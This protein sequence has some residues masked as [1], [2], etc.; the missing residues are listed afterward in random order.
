MARR[1]TKKSARAQSPV[2]GAQ[3]LATC[4]DS[5]LH[6][7]VDY[8]AGAVIGLSEEQF[9]ALSQAQALQESDWDACAEIE[10]AKTS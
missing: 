4:R 7:G 6:D 10:R 8:E 1:T 3:R 2:K 5:V 9:Q